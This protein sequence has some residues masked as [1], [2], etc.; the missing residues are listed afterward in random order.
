LCAFP[1]SVFAS[2]VTKSENTLRWVATGSLLQDSILDTS[3][4]ANGLAKT[5]FRV[6]FKFIS[7]C[8][9]LSS[10][11]FHRKITFLSNISTPS[12]TVWT[13][14]VNFAKTFCIQFLI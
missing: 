14:I 4:A 11:K 5:D 2:A 3:Q 10:N 8:E 9:L 12:A 7:S 13:K 1:N 6:K